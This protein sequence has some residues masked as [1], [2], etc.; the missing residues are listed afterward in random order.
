[1]LV[2]SSSES[3]KAGRQRNLFALYAGAN[4]LLDQNRIWSWKELGSAAAVVARE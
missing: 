3:E 4:T 2:D 1:V